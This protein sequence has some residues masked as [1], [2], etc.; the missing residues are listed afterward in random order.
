M[1]A[2]RIKVVTR[3][4]GRIEIVFGDKITN[5]FESM[6]DLR[7]WARSWREDPDLIRKMTVDSLLGS[8]SD[9]PT[10]KAAAE[11]KRFII[12]LD[13]AEKVV[14]DNGVG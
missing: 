7:R 12:D 4:G 8:A 1:P 5:Q 2:Q 9:F 14:I 10:F 6:A 13:V 3:Q 11:G